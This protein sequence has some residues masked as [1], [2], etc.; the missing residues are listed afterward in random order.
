MQQHILWHH[1]HTNVATLDPD[2]RSAEP[3]LVFHTYSDRDG[4]APVH[5]ATRFQQWITHAVLAFYGPSVVYNPYILSLRHNDN[6][7]ASVAAGAFMRRQ[8]PFALAM[9]AFYI[10]RIVLLPWWIGGMPLYVSVFV[11][12]V[13]VGVLL[14]FVFVVSHNFEGTERDPHKS[15][16]WYKAQ[17]ETSCSY[18]GFLAML[19]TGGLNFQIEHHIFPRLSSWHYPGL[20]GAVR[21]CC[22]RHGVK[23]TYYPSLWSN[24]KSMLKYM[25]SAGLM[26]VLQ[27]AHEE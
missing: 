19:L 2:A 1:P 14:T 16:C 21:D 9:R 23:Y 10:L 7:P 4:K 6:V 18:G 15:D 20:R 22:K 27:H 13:V 11:V 17:V 25:R 24:V 5:W 3:L 12:N 8:R 26:A